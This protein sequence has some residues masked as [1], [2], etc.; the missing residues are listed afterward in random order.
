MTN[1][2]YNCSCIRM[3]TTRGIA[4]LDDEDSGR[5]FECKAMPDEAHTVECEDAHDR[6]RIRE[7]RV[8]EMAEDFYDWLEVPS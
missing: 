5:C 3:G 6:R 8:A 7:E 1:D 4:D 2:N